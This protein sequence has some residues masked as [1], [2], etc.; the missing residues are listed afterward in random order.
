MYSTRRLRPVLSRVGRW[1][2][3][4]YLC[5]CF[6]CWNGRRCNIQTVSTSCGTSAP[7]TND[8]DDGVMVPIWLVISFVC[9]CGLAVLAAMASVMF[10]RRPSAPPSERA[11]GVR[12]GS[13]I[14]KSMVAPIV[15]QDS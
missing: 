7:G 5:S 15:E 10:W 6:V 2:A 8:E 4:R 9:V 1:R 14:T 13:S 11:D 12:G 3:R